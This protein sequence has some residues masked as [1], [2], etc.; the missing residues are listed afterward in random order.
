M[1]SREARGGPSWRISSGPLLIAV[2]LACARPAPLPELA[3]FETGAPLEAEALRARVSELD[4]P[5]LE[6]IPIDLGDGLGPSEAAV[7]AV[8]LNPDLAAARAARGEARAGLVAAGLLPNPSFGFESDDP[9][10][11]GSAGLSRVVNLSLSIDTQQILT[12]W[13]RVAAA[14]G[15]VE[16]VDLDIL[17]QEWGIAQQA[18]LEATRLAWLEQRVSLSRKQLDLEAETSDRL[19]QAFAAG[20]VAAG[21]LGVQIAARESVRANLLA[22]EQAH[23]ES[24]NRLLGLLGRPE[25]TELAVE[26]PAASGATSLPSAD[27]LVPLCLGRRLDLEA[28]RRSYAAQD[29][30]LRQAVIEQFPNVTVGLA[31]QRNESQLKFLGGFVTVGVPIFDRNQAGVALAEAT[32]ERLRLEY[33]ARATE[34]R[35]TVHDALDLLELVSRRLPEVTAGLEPLSVVEEQEARA[36]AAG[37]V[38]WLTYET[39][40]LALFEQ[41]LQQA[42][43]SQL[44]A[45][46]RI[47]LE[48]AC[49]SFG[50][51]M[52]PDR[53]GGP[54]GD[55]P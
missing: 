40:R 11:S 54:E 29:A 22:L 19:Q 30:R 1:A 25:P 9:Y 45:E 5:F 28:L 39:I 38:D 50:W 44:A 27:E 23:L 32:R 37:D 17:W 26:P 49:G 43:L 13:A 52:R 55:T 18:R 3:D 7:L 35:G 41:R 4:H 51:P 21:P 42:S 48:T 34:V 6:A 47:A 20:D 2:S 46:T 33:A 24:R 8:A 31:H 53:P 14:R 12:H 10:G 15:E 16:R 36:A